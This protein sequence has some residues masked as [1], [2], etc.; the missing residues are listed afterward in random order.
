M[1]RGEYKVGISF[2]PSNDT[3]VSIL[4]ENTALL[5][6]TLDV[7]VDPDNP[8]AQRCKA[9]AQTKY[10]EACMWGVKAITKPDPE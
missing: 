4:K 3:D 8:E 7:D 6:D 2:N 1:T 9:I 5:I 10:E